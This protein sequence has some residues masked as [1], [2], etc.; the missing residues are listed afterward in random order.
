MAPPAPLIWARF[1]PNPFN[2]S[3]T[4][5]YSLVTGGTVDLTV[6]D[7]L[8]RRVRTLVTGWQAT[9]SYRIGWSGH[10]VA[11]RPVATGVYFYRLTTPGTAQQTRRM[12]LVK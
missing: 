12:V 10:D 8:G 3:T 9:G 7:V 4:I 11:G 6:Y 1:Y 5:L 2:P